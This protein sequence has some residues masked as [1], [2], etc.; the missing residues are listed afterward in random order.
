MSDFT[1]QNR[2]SSSDALKLDESK[3]ESKWE[4]LRKDVAPGSVGYELSDLEALLTAREV[5]SSQRSQLWSLL[6][7]IIRID[8]DSQ[9]PWHASVSSVLDSFLNR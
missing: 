6:H 7:E 4:Q 3:V 2:L 8:L 1:L 5:Y 9:H